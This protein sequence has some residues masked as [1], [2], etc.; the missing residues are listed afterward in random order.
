MTPIADQAELDAA[1]AVN[2]RVVV[3]FEASWCGPCKQIAP[4]YAQ[5]AVAY[6]TI[7]FLSVDVDVAVD[8]ALKYDISSM[9]NF[10]T[11]R[12]GKEMDRFS[13]ANPERLEEKL[14]ALT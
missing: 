2:P 1:L 4:K 14:K 6:G 11:I 9:P 8:V 12:D 13:G 7:T 5:F 10:V 3:M